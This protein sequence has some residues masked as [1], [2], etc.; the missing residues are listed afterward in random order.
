MVGKYSAGSPPPVD[1]RR[2]VFSPACRYGIGKKTDC[3]IQKHS[4]ISIQPVN[5]LY[6]TISIEASV[7]FTAHTTDQENP[8]FIEIVDWLNADC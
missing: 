1:H 8:S 6:R 2:R 4:A 3:L 7:H 5:S